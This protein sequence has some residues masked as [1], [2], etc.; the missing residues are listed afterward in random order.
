[1]APR[2]MARFAGLVEAAEERQQM[3]VDLAEIGEGEVAG[4][5]EL[6][7]RHDAGAGGKQ[8]E[9][10]LLIHGE[11]RRLVDRSAGDQDR[12]RDGLEE[13]V[14]KDGCRRL[15]QNGAHARITSGPG[16]RE[17]RKAAEGVA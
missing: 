6:G 7:Q 16:E 8:I 3:T 12:N 15:R 2:Q 14:R 9:R 13:V 4:V 1:M 17:G 5:L 11:L 10:A